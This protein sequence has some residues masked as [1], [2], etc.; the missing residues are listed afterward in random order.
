MINEAREDGVSGVPMT[1]INDKW[2]VSGGQS[3][4][5]YYGVSFP[6]TL[7]LVN[8]LLMILF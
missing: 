1:I 3:A 2:A 8:L 7:F 6:W 4:D 5:V